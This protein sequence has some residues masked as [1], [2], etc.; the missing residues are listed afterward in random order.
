MKRYPGGHDSARVA[1]IEV[2]ERSMSLTILAEQGHSWDGSQEFSCWAQGR[3]SQTASSS[4]TPP[5]AAC[6]WPGKAW[7][8]R[9][10]R[11]RGSRWRS[12]VVKQPTWRSLAL[13]RGHV[14]C[15]AQRNRQDWRARSSLWLAQGRSCRPL[16]PSR[17][18]SRCALSTSARWRGTCAPALAYPWASCDECATQKPRCASISSFFA[19]R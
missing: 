5:I 3:T 11:F 4:S 12:A 19:E 6:F 17:V 8:G 10:W 2:D 1:V 16:A 7:Q 15:A 18:R 13:M 14:A 9:D